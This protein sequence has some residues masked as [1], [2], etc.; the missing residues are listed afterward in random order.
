MVHTGIYA[1]SAECIFKMGKGYDSTNVD[2]ARINELCLQCE[3]YIND[4]CRELVL[5]FMRGI[6]LAGLI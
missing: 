6:L 4:L 1:T 2:E 5:R 3:S